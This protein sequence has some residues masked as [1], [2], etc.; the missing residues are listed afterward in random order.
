MTRK[1]FI[2]AAICTIVQYYDYHL[3]GFFAARVSKHFFSHDDV[4]V[5]LIRTYM[6][7]AI[8]VMAKPIGAV[9]LGRIGDIYGRFATVIISLSGTAIA[10]FVISISPGYE[11]I[12]IAAAVILLCCRMC[13]ASLVSSGTDGIRIYI[14]EKIRA[15]KQCLGNGMVVFSTQIGSLIASLSAWFFSLEFMPSYSWRIA[16]L[17]GSFFGF[18]AIFLRLY[19]KIQNDDNNKDDPEY[20]IYKDQNIFKIAMQ[21]RGIFMTSVLTAG[22]IGSTYQ[23]III[24]FG[25][26]N[27]ELLR[28]VDQTRMQ[29]Y[30]S[31]GVV[32]YMIFAVVGSAFADVFGRVLVANI[33]SIMLLLLTLLFS[34]LIAYDS[35]SLSLY[36]FVI[37]VL[38]FVTM[39]ALTFMKQAIP[40][41]IRYRLFSLAHA[42]GSIII[43]APTAYISTSL[44]YYTK[45]PWL[46]IMYFICTIL[47]LFFSLNKLTKFTNI[48]TQK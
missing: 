6:I 17:L 39:P 16:F 21:N 25:T 40:K 7:M 38:P 37:V 5:Q 9:A 24:F 43:S 41:V 36:F 12:G 18:C 15:D 28:L 30:T 26:Y 31:I 13:I 35:F 14:F 45:L 23:F 8:G 48:S 19:S 47:V 44:Y 4:A 34:I 20:D 10:S 3:F 1:S 11:R 42:F 32:L 27:F 46:P 33:A 29:L 2:V 22:C